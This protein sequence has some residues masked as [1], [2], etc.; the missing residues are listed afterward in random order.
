MQRW[1]GVGGWCTRT[2]G[3]GSI[4]TARYVPPGCY[5]CYLTR[6]PWMKT[7]LFSGHK[8]CNIMAKKRAQLEHKQT[9]KQ[10]VWQKDERTSGQTG[11]ANSQ[12]NSQTEGSEKLSQ[13][14]QLR[15]RVSFESQV[16]VALGNRKVCHVCMSVCVCG[17]E[18]LI[19]KYLPGTANARS[20]C[21]MH[22][23]NQL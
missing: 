2:P 14:S 15:L 23:L 4:G 17:C 22:S 7:T 6:F 11:K 18:V 5:T 16:R 8:K 10:A 13:H 21:H 19:Y 9:N 12:A 3:S 1:L 20:P